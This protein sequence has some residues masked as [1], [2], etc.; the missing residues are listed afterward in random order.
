MPGH[1]QEPGRQERGADRIARSLR[2][3][4]GRA[5]QRS[6]KQVVL[7]LVTNAVKFTEADGMV[8]I[9][10]ERGTGRNDV[11]GRCGYRNWHRSRGLPKLGKPFMQA[12][13]STSRRYGGSGL[14]LAISSRLVELHGGMLTIKSALGPRHLGSGHIPRGTRHAGA[15]TRGRGCSKLRRWQRRSADCGTGSHVGGCF[16]WVGDWRAAQR[17]RDAQLGP[18]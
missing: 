4:D 6:I 10:I 16:G 7:N 18:C 8:S 3:R 12:D 13:A 5:D 15:G 9:C 17:R 11:S 14:G 1:D 2:C